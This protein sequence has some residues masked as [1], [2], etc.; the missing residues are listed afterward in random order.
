MPREKLCSKC[1]QKHNPPTGK[2]CTHLNTTDEAGL[3]PLSATDVTEKL[4]SGMQSIQSAMEL[5]N[6]RVGDLEAKSQDS[7]DSEKDEVPDELT[8]ER[9]SHQKKESAKTLRHDAALREAV[10]RRM[11]ELNLE[12]TDSE[13]SEE[14]SP[15]TESKA[16]FSKKGKPKKSGRVRTTEEVVVQNVAWPHF[17]VYRGAARDPA[18]FDDLQVDEFVF[19]YLQDVLETSTGSRRE[20]MIKHL[21]DLMG[22]SL[23]YGWQS[24]RNSHGI[25]LQK[26]ETGRLSWKSMETLTAIRGKYSRLKAADSQPNT[27]K[28]DSGFKGPLFCIPFQEGRCKQTD[29]HVTSRGRVM[30]ICA[31]CCKHGFAYRHPESECRKKSSQN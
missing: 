11:I 17:H 29:D 7:G 21:A 12:D 27:T 14:D 3:S 28:K 16:T 6:K 22:D 25:I 13:D 19:G 31:H 2:K 10:R 15:S 30:H 24:A 5:L 23:E 1:G 4:L 8:P 18:A 9:S 20:N 26:M